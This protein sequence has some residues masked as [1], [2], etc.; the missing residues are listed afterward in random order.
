MYQIKLS[1]VK[2][3]AYWIQYLVD[4]IKNEMQRMGGIY[5]QQISGQRFCVCFAAE[6]VKKNKLKYILAEALADLFVFIEKR[7]YFLNVLNIRFC[8]NLSRDMLINTLSNF[9][10]DEERSYILS[11]LRF[12]G[13]FNIDGFY[14][15]ALRDLRSEWRASTKMIKD[16][17]DLV[18]QEDTFNIIL[19]FLLSGIEAKNKIIAVDKCERGYTLTPCGQESKADIFSPD[20]LLMKLISI[21][22][23]KVI[24][25]DNITDTRLKRKL[26]GIF[27]IGEEHCE[28]L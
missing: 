3:Y 23:E 8:D 4:A 5:A 28:K 16:N 18:S 7:A 11:K 6:T 17:A 1:T 14:H 20:Q 10:S 9:N 15:F 13:D 12:S 22:P 25:N 27:C 24:L 21:A 2:K 19:K 26:N